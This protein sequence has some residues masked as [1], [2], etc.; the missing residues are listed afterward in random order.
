MLDLKKGK[1]SLILKGPVLCTFA[2]FR[3]GVKRVRPPPP[4]EFAKLN[5][6]DI[7]GN[8]KMSYFSYFCTS[9]V[10]IL[11]KVGPPWKNFLDPRLCMT[12]I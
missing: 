10:S 2:G 5:I 8:E 3:G 6:A 1:V 12:L 4:L 11:L 9:K 7:I